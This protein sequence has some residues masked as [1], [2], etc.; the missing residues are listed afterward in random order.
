MDSDDDSIVI[1]EETMPNRPRHRNWSNPQTATGGGSFDTIDLTSDD[2]RKVAARQLST[3]EIDLDGEEPA[4]ESKVLTPPVRHL[5]FTSRLKKKRRREEG[6]ATNWKDFYLDVE[7][8]EGEIQILEVDDAKPSAKAG[9][10]PMHM[11][12]AKVEEIAIEEMPMA[13]PFAASAVRRNNTIRSDSKAFR[14]AAAAVKRP[15][16]NSHRQQI[17]EISDTDTVKPTPISTAVKLSPRQS[18]MQQIQEIFPDMLPSHISEHLDKIE[19]IN[20]KNVQWLIQSFLA[21]KSYP[22]IE[23]KPPKVEEKKEVDYANDEFEQ[24][25]QYKYQANDRLL[26]TF[27]FMS[28]QGIQ[29]LLQKFNGRYHKTYMHIVNQMKKLKNFANEVEMHEE[30]LRLMSGGKLTSECRSKFALELNG[31]KYETTLKA[32]RKNRGSIMVTDAVLSDEIAFTKKIMR[33]WGKAVQME[34][35]RLVARKK[36]E[37]SGATVECTCCYGE[38]IMHEHC[39]SLIVS[40]GGFSVTNRI[41]AMKISR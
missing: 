30:F 10:M 23:K 14:V 22:K 2:D 5:A 4:D 17:Q 34:R 33:A 9:E 38:L 25:I 26:N 40:Y 3:I 1:L 7:G 37:E 16:Q 35:N 29:R 8:S 31:I 24:T 6:E 32:P 21:D 20:S 36:A 27:P 18:A 13:I 19:T 11:A 39:V 28:K 12:T 41:A 15:R